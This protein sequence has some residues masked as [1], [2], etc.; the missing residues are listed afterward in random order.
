MVPVPVFGG[1]EG[2]G[3]KFTCAIGHSPLHIIDSVSVPTRDA[4]TTLAECVQF[5]V[6]ATRRHG[7]IHSFGFGCFGPIELRRHS[8]EFGRMLPTPKPGWSGVDV[9]APLRAAFD[10]PISLDTD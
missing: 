7:A 9:L 6:D 5:F 3:T 10:V 4:R 1:V 2:G 8:G